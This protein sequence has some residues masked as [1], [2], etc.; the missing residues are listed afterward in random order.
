MVVN[1]RQPRPLKSG[2]FKMA[3]RAGVPVLPLFITMRD[4]DDLDADGYPRQIYSLH[5][6]PP[7]YPDL[8]LGEKRAA[9]KMKEENFRLWKETYER[10]YGIPLAYAAPEG[11][12][13]EKDVPMSVN[14]VSEG[15]AADE[16]SAG[17][18]AEKGERE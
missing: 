4:A 7:L 9:E 14:N 13:S 2:G 18:R 15:D 5:I 1:D 8:S 12:L 16:N 10:V 6:L 3:V 11:D 17:G